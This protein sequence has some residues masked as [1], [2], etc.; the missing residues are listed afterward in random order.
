MIKLKIFATRKQ[1]LDI[2][3]ILLVIRLVYGYAFILISGWKIKNPFTWIGPDSSYS[4]FFQAL[5]AVSEFYGGIAIMVGLFTRLGTF[6]IACTMAV[7]LHLH[8]FI[9]GDPFVNLTGGSSYQLPAIYFLVAILFLFMGPGRFSL[10][11]IIF[12]QVP[13][14]T[15]EK[16]D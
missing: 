9:M 12:G 6:G 1:P 10:D 4:G 15:P 3:I 8:H 11:R 13:Y 16:N 7:A 5:A 14:N 2:D